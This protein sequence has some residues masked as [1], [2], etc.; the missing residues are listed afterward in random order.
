MTPCPIGRWQGHE[1]TCGVDVQNI[2]RRALAAKPALQGRGG[3]PSETDPWYY[4]AHR[5]QVN[6]HCIDL[7][8]EGAE[9][10]TSTTDDPRVVPGLS[11]CAS[12]IESDSHRPS[13]LAV[14]AD[15]RD[16]R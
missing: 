3:E 14:R 11:Q 15:K 16:D 5:E 2:R 1:V 13:I 10:P 8:G 12:L 7:C 9:E 4:C 6:R